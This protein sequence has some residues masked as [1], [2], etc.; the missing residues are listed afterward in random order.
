ME[1]G[2]SGFEKSS[3]N[4][5]RVYETVLGQLQLNYPVDPKIILSTGMILRYDKTIHV[6]RKFHFNI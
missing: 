2:I 3:Y 4:P 6:K 1:Q 5:K